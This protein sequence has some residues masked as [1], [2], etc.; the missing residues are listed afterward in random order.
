MLDVKGVTKV[1]YFHFLCGDCG[2]TLAAVLGND[3]AVPTV[4]VTCRACSKTDTLKLYSTVQR[5]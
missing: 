4:T 5:A 3:G 1:D 2:A